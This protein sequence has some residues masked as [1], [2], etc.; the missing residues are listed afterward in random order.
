MT[1][2]LPTLELRRLRAD[3]LLCY[4]ILNNLIPVK[5]ESYGLILSGT[6]TRGHNKKLHLDHSGVGARRNYFGVRVVK[7]WNSLSNDLVNAP[8]IACFKRGLL[9]YNLS[10]FLRL[11]IN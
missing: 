7:P 11:D 4:K 3:L 1:L 10:T 2:G 5:P 8:S 9:K 6:I